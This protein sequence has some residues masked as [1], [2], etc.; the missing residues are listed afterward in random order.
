VGQAT[1]LA[2][3]SRAASRAYGAS[4]LRTAW[5]ARRLRRRGGFTYDE[6][7]RV[8]LLDPSLP[9]GERAGYVSRYFMLEAQGP[10]NHG[11]VVPWICADKATFYRYA[12]TL[13]IPVPE[14]YAVLD[15][16][17]SNWGPAAGVFRGREAFE[18][19]VADTLPGE[20]IIKP[21]KGYMGRAIY[22]F[23]KED[24]GLREI[25]GRRLS[26]GALWDELAAD[27]EFDEWIVQERLHNH[28]DLVRLAGDASLHSVR[29][30]TIVGRDGRP[31]LLFA[32][33]KLS[34]A[35]TASD[36]FLGGTTGNAIA[37]VSLDDGR[38]GPLLVRHPA[39]P[40]IGFAR[41]ADSPV[42]G[43]P[44]EGRA[45]PLWAEARRVVL[46]AAPRFLPTRSLGWDVALTPSGPVVVEG[47]TRWASLPLPSMR[48]V[49]ERIV[50]EGRPG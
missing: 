9:P 6:L 46:E 13:G 7:L 39:H 43:E 14:L 32:F 4:R 10:L 27:P 42:T 24:G 11:N 12:G 19:F 20:V 30:T 23:A 22:S 29:I 34:I 8:G 48:P 16:R 25:S 28:P 47:N 49:Y 41:L 35:G 3:A 15:R 21:S 17:G 45:L 1:E 50:A 40:G 36:N 5:T 44:A 37:Q 2:R 33:L 31:D 26:A 18:R 38:I